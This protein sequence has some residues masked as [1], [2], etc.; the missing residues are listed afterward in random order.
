MTASPTATLSAA[1]CRRPVRRVM[2]SG[3]RIEIV[4]P[5]S[6]RAPRGVGSGPCAQPK[7]AADDVRG[8]IVVRA[9]KR[10]ESHA[11]YPGRL[12]PVT[13]VVYRKSTEHPRLFEGAGE[14]SGRADSPRGNIDITRPEG[15]PA[16]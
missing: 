4:G 11:F 5:S 12:S 16:T 13:Q 9:T 6:S 1:G 3:L 14:P 2:E 15:G 10:V 8:K 7:A